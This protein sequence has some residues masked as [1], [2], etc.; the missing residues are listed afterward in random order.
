MASPFSTGEIIRKLRELD[1]TKETPVAWAFTTTRELECG[2][3]GKVIPVGARV[4]VSYHGTT[5]V[6]LHV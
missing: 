5:A 1:S 2:K 6:F 4:G 3:C